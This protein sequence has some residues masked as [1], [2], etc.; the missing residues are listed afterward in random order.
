MSKFNNIKSIPIE[1]I[2]KEEIGIAIK[3]WSEGD[4]SLENLLWTCYNKGIKTDSCH[5]GKQSYISFSHDNDSKILSNIVNIIHNIKGSQCFICMAGNPFSGPNWYLPTITIAFDTP[6]KDETDQY[7]DMIDELLKNNKKDDIHPLFK[8]FNYFL[9]QETNFTFRIRHL[10][11]DKFDF[12]IEH[13]LVSKERYEYYN[14]IFKSAGLTEYKHPKVKIMHFWK[15]ESNNLDEILLKVNIA[16]EYI[17]NNSFKFEI[18]N[19][20][21]ESLSFIEKA[22][23]MKK[24][25]SKNEFEK[26]L[27]KEREN[28]R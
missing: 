16:A 28:R 14:N 8:F 15:I 12:L 25:L 4:S 10:E 9:K 24:K 3:E 1:S 18:P 21:E 13:S 19:N 2:S 17:A 23:I 22:L 11:N 5:A 20:E 27:Q 7:F 6:Y 26:W